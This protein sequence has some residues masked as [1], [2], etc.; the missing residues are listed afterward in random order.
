MFH[1]NWGILI[2]LQLFREDSH[3]YMCA[4][5]TWQSLLLYNYICSFFTP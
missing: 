5:F 4:T 3:V 1:E 2:K